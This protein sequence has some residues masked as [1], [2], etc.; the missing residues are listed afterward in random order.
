MRRGLIR[1][2]KDMYKETRTTIRIKNRPMKEFER[3]KGVRQDR[4]TSAILFDDTW[5]M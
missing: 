5:Q 2:L 1:R 4:A 3:G